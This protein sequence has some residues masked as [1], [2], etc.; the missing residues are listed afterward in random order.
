MKKRDP[1]AY[2]L[3]DSKFRQRVVKSKKRPIRAKTK[4]SIKKE[5][6]ND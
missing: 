3:R 1:V 6:L 2:Q 5:F 4:R